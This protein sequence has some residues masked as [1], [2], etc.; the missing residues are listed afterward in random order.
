[1]TGENAIKQ[2]NSGNRK[3]KGK[4]S[5]PKAEERRVAKYNDPYAYTFKDK[6]LGEMKVLNSDNAW[7]VDPVK[8]NMLVAAYKFYATDAQACYYAG[9]TET[10]LKYFQELHPDF[11]TIKHAAKQ[12]PILRAKKR[13]FEEVEKS[14]ETAKWV[15]D[16]LEK[17]T[18]STKVVQE[19]TDK[20]Q[21]DALSEKLR[22]LSEKNLDIEDETNHDNR[23]SET[24]QEHPSGQPGA[25]VDANTGGAGNE[26]TPT[27]NEAKVQKTDTRAG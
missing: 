2:V 21:L 8:L 26:A 9:I 27:G 15:A 5:A 20:A 25:S 11:Y 6:N 10:Q 4:R 19:S 14:T 17:D 13:I 18:F 23:R 16:R 1:M 3:P 7:W 24:K 12:D 22:I